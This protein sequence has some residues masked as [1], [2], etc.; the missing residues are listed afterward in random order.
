MPPG[1]AESGLRAR[2]LLLH[3]GCHAFFAF[4]SVMVL[5]L[6]AG[7]ARCGCELPCLVLAVFRMRQQIFDLSCTS[8][9]EIS[10]SNPGSR[11]FFIVYSDDTD[12]FESSLPALASA[13]EHG[14]VA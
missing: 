7:L 3:F 8:N 13:G 9:R 12:F 1:A 6:A 11:V 10:G 4:F 5:V 2:S 14:L